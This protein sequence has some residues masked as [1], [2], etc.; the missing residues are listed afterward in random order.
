MGDSVEYPLAWQFE[1]T[2][3][4]PLEAEVPLRVILKDGRSF[5]LPERVTPKS[6]VGVSIEGFENDILRILKEIDN[7][8]GVIRKPNDSKRGTSSASRKKKELKKLETKMKEMSDRIVRSLGIGRNLGWV[9]LDARGSAGG[10]LVI[11]DKRVLEGLEAEPLS[12]VWGD[13]WCIAEDFNVVRFP[14]E[15]SNGRQMS[16]M[17]RDFSGFIEEF[18]LVDPPL[19]GGTFTW[20]GGE[21]GFLKAWLDRFLFS[22]D[23]EERM[24]GAMQVLLPRPVSDHWPILLDCGGMRIGKSP[25]RFENMWL[26]VEGFMDKFKDWWQSY[27]F[28]KDA[29]LEELKFWD[30]LERCGPLSEEDRNSQRIAR[31]EFSHC[32]ILEEISWRQKSRALWLKEGDSNIKFFH[33]MTN[34]RRREN[35][36]SSLTIRVV[37]LS[38]EEELR[39]GIGS[40]FKS[41]FEEPRVRRP[42][43]ESSLFKTLAALDNETLEGHFSEEEVYKA[44][45]ELEEIR[46][47]GRMVLLLIPKKEGA[48]DVQDFR[49]ISL[50]GSLYKIIAKVLANRMKRVM[51]KLVSY[52]Q[53]AFME[54]RQILDAVLVANEAID[55]RKRS[56][57]AGLV[58]KLDIE[59][60]YDHR[61]KVG[62]PLSPYLFVLIMEAFSSL[63]SKAEEKG[64]KINLK[65]SEIIPIGAVEDVEKAAAV[66]GCKVGNFP[67]TYLGLPLG[68]PHNSCKVWGCELIATHNSAVV[69][70]LWG[71]QGGGGGGWEVHFRRPFHDWELEEGALDCGALFFWGG[72]SVPKLKRNRR[73]FQEEEKS[74]TSL[75]N[76]FLR[77]LLEWSQQFMDVDYLSFMNMLGG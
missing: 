69:A 53:N 37:R 46:L 24:S 52:S 17:M 63:I 27:S 65:K 77:A 12:R 39:E 34:A 45:S 1:V 16:T 72:V 19:G 30:S 25:F 74:D 22:G 60:A 28:R 47:Q 21:R 9:S 64:L 7:R 67:T 73:M 23:W 55:L 35:F 41:L 49:P 43:V 33:R 15:K 42:D 31:D 62:R 44:I 76:L 18:E 38:K 29:A 2:C 50:L 13:P 68:A 4:D 70:D 56:A 14:V 58:C 10:V 6:R 11:W 59:K 48:S 8:R 40:Y 71:R 36:I 75:E 3:D 5:T 66:F 32:A 51:G 57:D 20:S 54:G 26:R 61:P